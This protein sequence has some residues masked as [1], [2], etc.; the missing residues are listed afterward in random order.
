MGVVRTDCRMKPPSKSRLPDNV[1][2]QLIR[3]YLGIGLVWHIGVIVVLFPTLVYFVIGFFVTGYLQWIV[4]V[5]ISSFWGPLCCK[6][7]NYDAPNTEKLIIDEEHLE[8]ITKTGDTLTDRIL[9]ELPQKRPVMFRSLKNSLSNEESVK[10]LLEQVNRIPDWVDRERIRKASE[11][12]NDNIT[13]IYSGLATGLIDSYTFPSDAKV[14]YISGGLTD[15]TTA[16][17]ARLERTVRFVHDVVTSGG[18]YPG[19]KAFDHILNVRLLHTYVRARCL[20]SSEWTADTIPINQGTMLGTLFF[21]CHVPIEMLRLRNIYVTPEEC[22][23]CWQL[24]RYVGYLLGIDERILP[25]TYN[26]GLASRASD[27]FQSRKKPDHT[28][29][30]LAYNTIV[31]LDSNPKIPFSK[32]FFH[33]GLRNFLGDEVCD[34]LNIPH[35]TQSTKI[36]WTIASYWF[37]AC[38]FVD[39]ALPPVKWWRVF[40]FDM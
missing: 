27:T 38:R 21:F 3:L 16:T 20:E 15:E 39:I 35:E 9:K 13:M 23:E 22:E 25:E 31:A 32:A 28:S 4:T 2:I 17:T 24:W 14:L 8:L 19:T 6:I 34:K 1:V 11:F 36:A 33:V 37:G 7:F 26:Y 18:P 12:C 29:Q 10:D 40:F 30:Q 5:L